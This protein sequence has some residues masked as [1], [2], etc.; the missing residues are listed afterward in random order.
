MVTW[1]DTMEV[2]EILDTARERI[3]VRYPGE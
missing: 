2:M 3:G 1:Q